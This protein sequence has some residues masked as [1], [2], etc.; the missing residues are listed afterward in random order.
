[1]RLRQTLKKELYNR[2]NTVIRSLS[3][4]KRP[5]PR[6]NLVKLRD[7][8]E[9]LDSFRVREAVREDIPALAVLHA[10]AWSETYWNVRNPP[11]TQLREQQWRKQFDAADGSWFCLLIENANGQLVGFAK[12]QPYQ[13]Q[14]LPD[15]NGELNKLYLLQEYQRLGL[16]R[17]L[18]QEVARQFLRRGIHNMVL[19]GIPQNPSCKFHEA[20]GGKRLYA[21]NGVFH[22][23]YGW[24]DLQ[25]LIFR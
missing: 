9:T 22:G 18:I 23:G 17:Q 6:V 25:R 10:R 7:R 21:A 3:A 2:V 11:T 1:M 24:D 12:G 13:H 16:G 8:G 19:F 5:S 20:M 15:Y 4:L 14:D